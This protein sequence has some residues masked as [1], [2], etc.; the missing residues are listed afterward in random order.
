I[1]A[2]PGVETRWLAR[3]RGEALGE[4]TLQALEGAQGAKLWF[5][6]EKGDAKLIRDAAKAAGWEPGGLRV[7]GFWSAPA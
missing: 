4:A 1:E 3:A 7:S 2:P 5:A 6:G